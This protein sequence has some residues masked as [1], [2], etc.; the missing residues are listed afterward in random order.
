MNGKKRREEEERKVRGAGKR[1]REGERCGLVS[2]L[3]SQKE[4]REEEEGEKE[5]ER[6]DEE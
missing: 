1:A 2:L 4:K 3:V 6:K 5:A